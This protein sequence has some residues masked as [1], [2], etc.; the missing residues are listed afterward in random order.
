MV[1]TQIQL[2]E[3]QVNILKN[4]AASQNLSIAE[5]IRR[6]VDNLIKTNSEMDIEERKRRAIEIAGRFHSG[7]RN[8]STKHDRYLAEAIKR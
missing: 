1:R 7:K 3:N 2:T 4:M 8:I 6:A 5:L